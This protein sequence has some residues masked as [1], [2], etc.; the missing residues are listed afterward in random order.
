[1]MDTFFQSVLQWLASIVSFVWNKVL[2]IRLLNTPLY[3]WFIGAL[4]IGGAM[5][6]ILRFRPQ[7]VSL[8]DERIL[9]RSRARV[10]AEAS[11]QR[12]QEFYDE[13]ASRTRISHR[14]DAVRIERAVRNTGRRR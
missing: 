6:L 8:S 10:E 2:S 3:A 7:G 13:R 11:F 1:M 4:V 14:N 9:R 5:A 12:K